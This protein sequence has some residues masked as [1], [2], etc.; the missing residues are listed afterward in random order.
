MPSKCAPK[1]I[2]EFK[3]LPWTKRKII[4]ALNF[5][6]TITLQLLQQYVKYEMYMTHPKM[7][8]EYPSYMRLQKRKNMLNVQRMKGK[9]LVR[10]KP[11][12]NIN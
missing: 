4:K 10:A 11:C 12:I 2:Q 5:T 7:E 8:N 6:A 1:V 9:Y 3:L